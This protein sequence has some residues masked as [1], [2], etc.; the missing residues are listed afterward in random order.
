MCFANHNCKIDIISALRI[1]QILK[2][3]VKVSTQQHA[4]LISKIENDRAKRGAL[5]TKKCFK[6]VFANAFRIWTR[7]EIHTCG[8][9]HTLVIHT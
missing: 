4:M 3:W 7:Y 6:L 1:F 2:A 5:F 8:S 9:F